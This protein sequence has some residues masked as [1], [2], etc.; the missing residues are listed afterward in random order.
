MI[1]RVLTKATHSHISEKTTFDILNLL[2][3]GSKHIDHDAK[4][5]IEF[6]FVSH[7]IQLIIFILFLQTTEFL[8]IN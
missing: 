4:S 1:Y 3:N 5:S 7:V 8:T 2:D 6:G